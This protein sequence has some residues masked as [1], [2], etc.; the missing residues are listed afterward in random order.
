MFCNEHFDSSVIMIGT[1]VRIYYCPNHDYYCLYR[2][3]QG[4]TFGQYIISLN[5]MHTHI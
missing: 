4:R 2:I 5:N 3:H 1:I